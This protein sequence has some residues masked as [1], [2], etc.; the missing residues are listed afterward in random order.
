M[1][2]PD[3]AK[4]VSQCLQLAILLEVSTNKPGNVNFTT[5][6]EGTRAEHFLASAVAAAPSFEEAAKR[7]IAIGNKTLSVGQARI[8]QIIR[9]CVVDIN[10]WQKGGNTLLGTV[11]LFAPIAVAAGMTKTKKDFVFDMSLLR[12]N[13]KSVVESTTP[14]DAVDLYEAVNIANPSGLNMSNELDVNNP[15]SKRQ[16][17]KDKI[18]LFRV[19]QIGASYDDVCSEWVNNYLIN[20][21]EA[22][23]YLIG[24][25]Q[26]KDDDLN[27]AI[28][29]T[30]LKILSDHP[31]TFIARKAGKEKAQEISSEAKKA[32]QLGGLESVAGRKYINDLDLK[33]RG[34][35]NRLNPGTTADM[36]A[37][38]LALLVLSGYRP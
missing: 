7:G 10:S 28:V 17:I 15:N 37:V 9:N 24:K 29:H 14:Q 34:L 12:K 36:T 6:F 2:S 16:L 11:M 21:T 26:T 8:G 22:F 4:H 38:S 35:G 20:F 19:F 32:L 30:F 13:V 27:H 25:L 31:D 23:P 5:G 3:K 33:L 18:S 1:L